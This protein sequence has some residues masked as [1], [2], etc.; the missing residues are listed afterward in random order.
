MKKAFLISIIIFLFSNSVFCKELPKE[1]TYSYDI[2]VSEI[3]GV[4]KPKIIGNHV[5]FTSSSNAKS[6]GIAFDFENFTKIHSFSLRKTY[7]Y[8]GKETGSWYFYI[9][10][11]PKKL[12]S[13]SYKLIIDGLWT[14]DPTNKNSF[15]DEQNG[16][17]LSLLN[18][19]E[20]KEEVTEIIPE[21]F[22]KF[23][24]KGKSGQKIRLGGTF[25]N[26]DSWIYELDEV[27][28][29]KY[30]IV[31]PLPPGTYYYAYYSGLESFFDS[32]NPLKAYSKDGKIVSEI[33]VN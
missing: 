28:S 5:I 16:I 17:Q 12:K 11:I 30:E 19:P 4:Q 6:V 9:L 27:E 26:W 14:N 21:G 32:T 31:L 2:L 24:Y 33:T 22:T 13:L 20:V 23:V 8:E 29:G 15:Y 1:D 3:S 18:L 25:T 7:D 10:E